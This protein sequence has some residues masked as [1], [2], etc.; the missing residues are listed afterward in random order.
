MLENDYNIFAISETDLPHFDETKPFS[1][2]GYKTHWPKIK[3]GDKYTRMLCFVKNNLECKRRHDL[4]NDDMCSIWLELK[5]S[6]G[7]KTLFCTLYREFHVPKTSVLIDTQSSNSQEHQLHRLNAFGKNLSIACTEEKEVYM[8]GDCNLD[9]MKSDD[10]TFYLKNILK[11]YESI[12]GENGLI[13]KRLGVTFE[14]I[15]NDGTVIQSELDHLVTNCPDEIKDCGTF[16]SD[17]SPDHR[18]IY[19]EIFFNKAKPEKKK[20][21]SR[22]LRGIRKNPNLLREAV[23]R[24]D[25]YQLLGMED[26]D[27]EEFEDVTHPGDKTKKLPDSR[28]KTAAEYCGSMIDKL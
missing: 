21:V 7:K 17:A 25:W 5:N 2:K 8:M 23:A 27:I 22:D 9:L 13:N 26:V 10:D 24:Q 3:P 1:L 6:S 11:E 15:H 16:T 20:I 14:R 28:H 4:E 18:V 12:L 19:A